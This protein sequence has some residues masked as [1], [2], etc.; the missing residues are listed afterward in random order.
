MSLTGPSIAGPSE[1]R[2]HSSRTVVC[3]ALHVCAALGLG[4]SAQLDAADTSTPSCTVTLPPAA[5][6]KYGNDAL[7]T[8]L[9]KGGKIVFEPGGPG[10]VLADGSLGIKSAWWRLRSGRLTVRGRRLDEPAAPLRAEITDGYRDT[11]FQPVALIFPTPGCWEITGEL[12]NARL[13]F[14]TLVQKVA[15]GPC[16]KAEL[17]PNEVGG[18]F[19]TLS[20]R[21]E[22]T[23]TF[24]DMTLTYVIGTRSYVGG[25]DGVS[26]LEYFVI[27]RPEYPA[28]FLGYERVEGVVKEIKGSFAVRHSGIVED[29]I[30]RSSWV[31][32]PSSGRAGLSGIAGNGTYVTGNGRRACYSLWYS[33]L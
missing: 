9:H 4:W 18:S 8:G 24:G 21:E 17:D 12:G 16:G 13:T 6:N 23:E 26:T 22:R 2:K 32:L 28:L 25:I 10:F 15:D 29:N 11:G 7:V 3:S 5:D 14:V 31:V 27:R 1:G 33:G 20:W 30:A 19:E